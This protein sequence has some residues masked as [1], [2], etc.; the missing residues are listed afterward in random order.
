MLFD[1]TQLYSSTESLEEAMNF[2]IDDLFASTVK[3]TL[4]ST[5]ELKVTVVIDLCESADNEPYYIMEF[6][7]GGRYTQHIVFLTT[8][9]KDI[10]EGILTDEN[11]ERLVIPD[12]K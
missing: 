11:K 8:E 3:K 9:L 7:D 12:S 4:L 5:A 6:M 2:S 10:I 1:S